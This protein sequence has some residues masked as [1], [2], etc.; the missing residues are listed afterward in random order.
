M[1]RD[2]LGRHLGDFF[3]AIRAAQLGG[4]YLRDAQEDDDGSEPGMHRFSKPT[5]GDPR[6]CCPAERE[7]DREKQADFMDVEKPPIAMP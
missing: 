4:V 6:E 3:A 7:D 5:A 2:C 1:C